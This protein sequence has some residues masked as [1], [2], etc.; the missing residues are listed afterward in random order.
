MP[1]RG[2]G[3]LDELARWAGEV[4]RKR[5]RD[6]RMIKAKR[7]AG[8]S[9]GDGDVTAADLSE[10]AERWALNPAACEIGVAAAEALEDQHLLAR[11]SQ[12]CAQAYNWMDRSEAALVLDWTRRAFRAYAAAGMDGQAGHAAFN[13]GL[14]HEWYDMW[15]CG[16]APSRR[17]CA[18]SKRRRCDS[19]ER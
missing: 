15:A 16:S 6:H 9:V 1:N 13:L 19:P 11:L 5:D 7:L 2:V 17:S 8:A 3:K 4:G 10:V 14:L 18:T 12:A